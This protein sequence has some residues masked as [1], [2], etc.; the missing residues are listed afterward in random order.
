[1]PYLHEAA[2]GGI[3]VTVHVQPKASKN[4]IVGLHGEALKICITSPPVDNKAN[5]AVSAFLAELFSLPRSSVVLQS[6]QQS[7][8]KQ[9]HLTG[10][11]LAAVREIIEPYL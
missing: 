3:V 7:R 5:K 1:M 4:R 8:I 9:F 10:L 2:A 11:S 6:G